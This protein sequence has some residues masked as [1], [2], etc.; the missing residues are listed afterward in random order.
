MAGGRLRR[1]AERK[2]S[3]S[4]AAT[5]RRERGVT[6]PT[7]K[8]EPSCQA[9]PGRAPALRDLCH[10]PP[11]G[12]AVPPSASPGAAS[13]SAAGRAPLEGAPAPRSRLRARLA[14]AGSLLLPNRPLGQ[15]RTST[16]LGQRLPELCVQQRC[17]RGR[18][19]STEP[20]PTPQG[21]ASPRPR[22]QNRRQPQRRLMTRDDSSELDRGPETNTKWFMVFECKHTYFADTRARLSLSLSQLPCANR[23]IFCVAR[24]FSSTLCCL[25]SAVGLPQLCLDSPRPGLMPRGIVF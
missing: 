2:A 9:Q 19:G 4:Q 25:L 6:K 13:P 20:F 23:K 17:W 7:P 11:P 22:R 12:F 18:A 8:P 5:S 21:R 10:R 3:S 1:L 14:P 24:S 15:A 16:G